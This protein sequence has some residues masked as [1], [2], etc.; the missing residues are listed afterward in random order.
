MID[1][2]SSKAWSLGGPSEGGDLQPGPI[3]TL[4]ERAR[5][6]KHYHNFPPQPIG[7]NP[8]CAEHRGMRPQLMDA[9]TASA[10]PLSLIAKAIPMLSRPDLEALTERLI[11]RLDEV[12]GDPDLEDATDT[13]DDVLTP[14][15]AKFFDG[16]GC[17]IADTPEDEDTYEDEGHDEHN[18]V[19]AEGFLA[20]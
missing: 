10:L 11:D 3:A 16:P 4:I 9:E 7:R 8:V 5:H 14:W 13:E 6:D 17:P 18:L 15:G 2:L 12:D 19:P 20:A 1:R